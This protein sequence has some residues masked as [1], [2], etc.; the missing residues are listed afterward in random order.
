LW[1]TEVRDGQDAEKLLEVTLGMDLLAL[2]S[3]SE[4]SWNT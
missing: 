2:G 1:R 3:M 4:L